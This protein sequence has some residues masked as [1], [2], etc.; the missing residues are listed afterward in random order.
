MKI[1]INYD[2]MDKIREAKTGF[3]LQYN[4]YKPLGYTAFYTALKLSSIMVVPKTVE[5]LVIDV[6][7]AFGFYTLITA[8]PSVALL[9]LDRKRATESLKLL[10]SRLKD[11]NVN[12]N[13][14]LLL[15]SYNYKT[16]YKVKFNDYLLPYVEQNKYISVPTIE[17]G[18]EK[19]TS[20]LQEHIIGS[21]KYALSY[22][23]P[24][25]K[26]VLKL[27]YNPL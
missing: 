8:I 3:N 13:H 27:A 18:E 9:P 2:L 23:S 4:F 21:R 17:N 19:E 15:K 26:K 7:G 20:L 11:I 1:Q 14:E 5:E 22:G 6:I 12:T 25:E 24:K 10:S 16:E